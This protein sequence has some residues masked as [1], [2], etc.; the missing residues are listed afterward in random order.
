MAV[1]SKHSQQLRRYFLTG[2]VVLVPVVSTLLMVKWLFSLLDGWLAPVVQKVFGRHIPGLGMFATLLLILSVG[3]IASHVIGKKLVHLFDAMLSH[4][5][6]LNNVYKTLKRFM[7]MF[8]SERSQ[9]LKDVVLIEYPRSG[10]YSLGFVTQ[11][12]E[13]K[14]RHQH[15]TM[16]SVFIPTN[17]LYLGFTTI[18][19]K[20]EVIATGL[21]VQEGIQCILTAGASLPSKLSA[22][23]L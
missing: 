1:S 19:D 16:I 9:S 21:T 4:I 18:V 20:S 14:T 23:P 10:V 3:F 8:S 22:K 12:L 17:H 15:S 5:P 7:D 11:E 6:I 13:L 2:L